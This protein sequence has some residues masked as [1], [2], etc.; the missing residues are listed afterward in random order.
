MSEHHFM[1]EESTIHKNKD[2][3]GDF[4]IIIKNQVSIN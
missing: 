4:D 1:S 3:T 2:K